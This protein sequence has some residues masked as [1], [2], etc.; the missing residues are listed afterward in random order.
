MNRSYQTTI[1]KH[2]LDTWYGDVPDVIELDTIYNVA[3][4]VRGEVRLDDG[5]YV[6]VNFHDN[7]TVANHIEN[8]TDVQPY[9]DEQIVWERGN[10]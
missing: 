7:E 2:E 10:E 9:S 5:T 3:T 4:Y 1:E 6:E 8:P